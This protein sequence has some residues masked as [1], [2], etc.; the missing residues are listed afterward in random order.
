MLQPILQ[1]DALFKTLPEPVVN[2]LRAFVTKNGRDL[3]SL[4][5][6]YIQIG[7]PPSRFLS[8]PPSLPPS[9]TTLAGCVNVTDEGL[10][11]SRPPRVLHDDKGKGCGR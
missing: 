8:S 9:S 4:T 11:D 6:I 2:V 10:D 1:L 3:Y 5:E 7:N